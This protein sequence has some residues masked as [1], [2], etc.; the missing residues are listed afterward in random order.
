[1][2]RFKDML[3]FLDR[4]PEYLRTGP[5][6]VEA[7]VCVIGYGGYL[8]WSSMRI[9]WSAFV[10]DV[11]DASWATM[12]GSFGITLQSFRLLVGT[13]MLLF[14]IGFLLKTGP[15]PLV[16]YTLTSWNVLTLRL[17]SAYAANHPTIS[18]PRIQSLAA[19]VRYPALVMNSIT[20]IVWWTILVPVVNHLLHDEKKRR[21]FKK[22]NSS[23]GLINIHGVNL[24]IAITEFLASGVP[25]QYGD[26]HTSFIVG[27]VYIIFYLLVL[28]NNG[29]QLYIVF[30]PRT[31]WCLVTFSLLPL[32][33]VTF[34]K[35]YNAMIETTNE[36]MKIDL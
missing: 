32:L 29:I 23:F 5:W 22:F 8:L 35:G 20:V 16:T 31:R 2:S 34:Y 11:Y 12:L 18:S 25:L 21:D 28:D 14:V 27:Y 6:A 19:F 7:Y 3:K 30:T 33:Y 17:L 10:P 9:E 13:Y 1:M 15:W 24:P 4:V 26:L 36:N